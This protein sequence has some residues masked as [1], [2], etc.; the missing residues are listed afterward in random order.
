ML[1][2]GCCNTRGMGLSEFRT[3]VESLRL[4]IQELVDVEDYR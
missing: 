3:L 1:G 4:E 2:V